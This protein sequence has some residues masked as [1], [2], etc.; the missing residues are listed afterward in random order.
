MGAC[1]GDDESCSK[2][3]YEDFIQT[4]APINPGN[5]GGGLIDLDGRLVGINTA[6][7]SPGGGNVGIGFAVPINMA[8]R[9][10]E[11]LVEH[12]RV[13][14]GRIGVALEDLPNAGRGGRIEG[15]LVGQ[16]IPGSPADAAGIRKGD[17]VVKADGAAIRTAAQLRNKLGLSRIGERVRL[18][19]ERAGSQ[20]TVLVEVAAPQAGPVT[21]SRRP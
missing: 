7:I 1:H 13:Q 2:Q 15:V 8:R 10:M 20:Q 14:R 9:V 17:V 11:Q 19:F 3:G 5:S 6:I 12:G 21:S 4:D 18:T 16:V